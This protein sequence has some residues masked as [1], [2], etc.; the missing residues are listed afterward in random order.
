MRSSRLSALSFA[1]VFIALSAT[2]AGAF[3]PLITSAIDEGELVTL[4]G[5]TPPAAA[6]APG[7]G[8]A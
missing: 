5:N 1:P 2:A 8:D 7:R 3:A 4:G 6:L